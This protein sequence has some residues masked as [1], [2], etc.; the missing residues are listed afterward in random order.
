[1]V[2]MESTIP[3]MSHD[4][5]QLS[6]QPRAA[7]W[8]RLFGMGRGLARQGSGLSPLN[9]GALVC[10]LLWL[11]AISTT[12]QFDLDDYKMYWQ[13]AREVLRTG[14]PYT[15]TPIWRTM[16]VE[17]GAPRPKV[18]TYLYPPLLAYLLQP[19]GRLTHQ[20]GQLI[21]F[22]INCAALLSF[23]GLCVSLSGSSLARRF[24]GL[25]LLGTV[26]SPPVRVGL[27]LGQIGIWIAL[28]LV[29][30]V[31]LARRYPALGGLLL[32]FASLL[33][34]YPAFLGLFYLVRRMGAAVGWTIVSGMLLL[35][36]TLLWYGPSPYRNYIDKVLLGGFYPYGAEFNISLT[37]FWD[38]LL[39]AG[40]YAIPVADL[41]I[42]AR[43]LTGCCAVAVLALCFYFGRAPLD[44]DGTLVQVSLW[45]CGMLLLTPVNG[46]YNL[47]L[48]LLPLLVMLRSI[49]QSGDRRVRALLVIG[50]ALVWVPPSWSKV[51]PWLYVVVHKEWGVLLLTP[52]FYGLLIFF[53]LL[54][55]LLRRTRFPRPSD[56]AA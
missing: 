22:G 34:L 48:L 28:L 43:V 33:K 32:A 18:V 41:P 39:H 26:L 2:N 30:S 46:Y 20:P 9:L 42:L 53:G 19:L 24:W 5:L 7:G 56:A 8:R 40:L 13:A 37:G 38:R 54:V 27:Q 44:S 3:P 31:A 12:L 49:E 16:A 51:W 29:S 4:T 1:M 36:G 17:E 21:W 15:S 25:V 11:M 6:A 50:T 23:V 52:A 45:L 10:A 55:V 47:V 35:A 14:D